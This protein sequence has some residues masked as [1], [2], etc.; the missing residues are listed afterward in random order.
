VDDHFILFGDSD[1]LDT[2][3]LHDL[4]QPY[5]R[6]RN[7][8]GRPRQYSL[9]MG[10]KW[11]LDLVRLEIVLLLTQDG[12]TVLVERSTGSEMVLDAPYGTPR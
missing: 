9:V 7:H 8:F 12:C 4:R 10:L 3:Q 5:F 6:L 11:K 2:R 1:N